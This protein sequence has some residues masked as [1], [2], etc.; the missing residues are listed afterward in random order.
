MEPGPARRDGQDAHQVE[1]LSAAVRSTHDLDTATAPLRDFYP[2][3]CSY[4][5]IARRT[6]DGEAVTDYRPRLQPGKR[7]RR[8]HLPKLS[9]QSPC[10]GLANPGLRYVVSPVYVDAF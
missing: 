6:Q 8:D 1:R 10:G 5:V 4:W 2:R 3:C 7:E 9:S